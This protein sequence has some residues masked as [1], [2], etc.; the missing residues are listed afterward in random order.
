VRIHLVA[1]ASAA[2]V[3]GA[4][5]STLECPS[6]ATV[7]E[8]LDLLEQ[9]TPA[10]GHIRERLAVAVD[11]RLAGLETTLVEGVEVALL[12]PVSG[13]LAASFEH[14]RHGPLDV[15]SVRDRISHPSRGAV[16]LF[17]GCVR[18]AHAGRSVTHLTYDAYE[19]MADAALA[20]ICTEIADSF[21]GL[22]IE[23]THRLGDVPA[24][25]PSVVIATASPH[26]AEAYEANRQ[27]L[28]RLKREVPIWKREHFADGTASWREVESLVHD[29]SR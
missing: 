14:L 3:L 21:P 5:R 28:E 8:V 4:R 11:G 13:G 10:F 18:S 7:R 23:I 1:F 2:E 17:L 9:A 24:G 6:G 29:T 27:A 16:L 20:A 15:E 12:P 25:E 19:T 26:R 22:Q